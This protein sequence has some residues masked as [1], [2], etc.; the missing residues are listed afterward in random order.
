MDYEFVAKYMPEE[1]RAAYIAKCE[2]WFRDNAPVAREVPTPHLKPWEW[3]HVAQ[4]MPNPDAYVAKWSAWFREHKVPVQT[5]VNRAPLLALMAKYPQ[6]RPPLAEKIKAMSKAGY[7][8]A[9]LERT[10]AYYEWCEEVAGAQ[11]KLFEQ[12]FAQW[13]SSGKSAPKVKKVIK[14]VK[15]RPVKS[16]I[17]NTSNEHQE[18][19]G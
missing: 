11:Q 5:D 3:R 7:S 16:F 15:K 6:S 12:A 19:L 13:P 4:H 17:T 2:A 9:H 8:D 10:V 18:E 1:Q 14:A